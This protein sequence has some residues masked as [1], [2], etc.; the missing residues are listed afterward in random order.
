M[1]SSAL[2]GYSWSPTAS[3][4]VEGDLIDRLCARDR[5][6]VAAVY[7]AHHQA[8]RAFARR[9]VGEAAAAEDLVQEVFL[10]L[11]NAARGFRRESSLRTLLI[12]IAINH[13][14]HQVRAAARRRRALARLAREP[15][16]PVPSADC[17]AERRALA[18]SLTQAMDRLSLKHRLVFLLCEV[19]QRT[20]ADA[21]VLLG[22]PEGTVRTRLHHAREKLRRLLSAAEERP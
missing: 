7:D 20:S 4:V 14:R 8:V 16:V 18:A 19:E 11:P 21:A 17:D 15:V 9:L 5:T 10:V 3:G 13:A 1:S 6:A 12:S 2:T 22:I